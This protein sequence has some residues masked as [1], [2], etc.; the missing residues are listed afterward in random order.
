LFTGIYSLCMLIT[1]R[2]ADVA[3]R[4]RLVIFSLVLWSLATLGTGL[5]ISAPMFLFWRAVMGITESLYVSRALATI[6]VLHAGATRSRALA[7]H[8]SAQFAGIV[9]GDWYGGWVADHIG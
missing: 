6:A 3:Q 9:G 7:I 2:L 5:S 1:G 8:G 4:D